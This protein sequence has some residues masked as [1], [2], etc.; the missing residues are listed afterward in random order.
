MRWG[1]A[2]GAAKYVYVAYVLYVR[3]AIAYHGA[4]PFQKLKAQALSPGK[5]STDENTVCQPND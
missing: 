4:H 2:G 1:L 3:Y 5:Y